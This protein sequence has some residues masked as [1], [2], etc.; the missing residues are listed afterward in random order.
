MKLLK[1]TALAE[2]LTEAQRL[3]QGAEEKDQVVVLKTAQGKLHHCINR[4][5]M[6]GNCDWSEEE[7]LLERLRSSGDTQV[8][9]V[10][11]WWN[12][13]PTVPGIYPVDMISGHLRLGLQALDPQNTETRVMLVGEG[14]YRAK[15][16]GDC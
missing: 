11:A 6:T 4:G 14:Y 13:Q 3:T 8:E 2:L 16:L 12:V 1:E 15:R 9:Y 7:A 5:V 10:I